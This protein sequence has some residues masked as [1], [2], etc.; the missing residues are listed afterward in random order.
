MVPKTA[1]LLDQQIEG[2]NS[3]QS[4]WF[5]TLSR[6]LLPKKPS[7]VEEDRVILR[8]DLYT[9]Y[10]YHTRVQGIH[11]RS[12]ET[13]LGMFLKKQL[14]AKLTHP[15]PTGGTPLKQL[16]CY[17]LPPLQE[18]RE[19]FEKQLGQPVDWDVTGEW[20]HSDSWRD[21]WARLARGYGTFFDD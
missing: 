3:E 12:I 16:S 1:A 6:G 5:E 10:V 19:L 17:G 11:R 15:R 7:G 9:S 8:D 20:Q 4:W 2:M 13:K 21:S 18:C 14:G